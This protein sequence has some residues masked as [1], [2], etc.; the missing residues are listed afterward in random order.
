M[1]SAQKHFMKKR[2][3]SLTAIISMGLLCSCNN[4]AD[5]TTSS[6]STTVT[7]DSTNMSTN[8]TMDTTTTMST[9]M[10]P[11]EKMDRDFVMKAASGGMMEVELGNM[12]QQNASSQRVKDFGSM[13]VRDH[14]KANDELMSFASRRNLM[15][16]RDSLMNLHKS[17]MDALK[18]KTGAAFDK[19]YMKMMVDDHKEDVEEFEK[20]SKM[21]KDQECLS[22]AS[23]TLPVLQTHLD[24]AQA[25]NKSIK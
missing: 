12:A 17:D 13:M 16:N 5:T 4:N 8:T 24:S 14:S 18:N 23:K 19:A 11:L 10:A 3:L 15:L 21:C 2:S 20:A 22:F 7:T 6:D 9:N 25:I 1:Y